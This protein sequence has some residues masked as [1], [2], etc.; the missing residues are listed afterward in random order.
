MATQPLSPFGL[1]LQ[2]EATSNELGSHS[3]R[4]S[5]QLAW[6]VL[7]ETGKVRLVPT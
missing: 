2:L 7:A 1:K 3:S 4:N 5:I 6:F